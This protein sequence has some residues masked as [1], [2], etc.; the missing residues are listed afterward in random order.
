MQYIRLGRIKIPYEIKQINDRK[1]FRVCGIRIPFSVHE[2]ATGQK[3]YRVLG[4]RFRLKCKDKIFVTRRQLNFQNREIWTEEDIRRV[5]EEIFKEKLGYTPDLDEPKSLNE[6]IFWMKLNYHDPLVTKCCDKF[7]VKEYV[8]E[9]LGD[10]FVVP[11]IGS[12]QSADEIDFDALPDQFVLKV[13]WS[14]GYNIIV[15]DKNALDTEE[16]KK[17]ISKWLQPQQNSYYQT[18]NWGYKHMEPVVYAEKYIEQM[19]GQLYDYKFYCCNGKA[20]FLF[21]ATNRF[22]EEGVTYDFF[23]MN[24]DR[25]DLHYGGRACSGEK[26]EKP[27]F[28]EEMIRCAELLAKPF[29]FVRIDFY[30]QEDRIYVGEMTFYSGGGILPFEPIDWDYKLGEHINLP[31]QKG[32]DEDAVI[33]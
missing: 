33:L 19:D 22:N 7:R 27:R 10:G 14:S 12:W 16:A 18:F 13:N 28:F 26:L 3:Y 9:K 31:L 24:F 29:P 5:S 8:T 30:E 17:K 11:V 25:L 2:T 1:V 32:T 21:I 6:K 23:D 15:K 4:L 20:E